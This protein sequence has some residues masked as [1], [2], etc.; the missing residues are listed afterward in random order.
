M[1]MWR[2]T[3]ARRSLCFERD[4]RSVSRRCRI[5]GSCEGKNAGP[6]AEGRKKGD[7]ASGGKL[8]IIKCPLKLISRKKSDCGDRGRVIRGRKGL[9]RVGRGGLRSEDRRGNQVHAKSEERNPISSKA[10][11]QDRDVGKR[12]R[13]S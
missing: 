2:K 10:T 4:G 12:K 1:T 9:S 7:L 11:S 3:G 8:P 13:A 6:S 5:W